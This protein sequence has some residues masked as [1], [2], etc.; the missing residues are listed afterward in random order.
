MGDFSDYMNDII[1]RYG[2]ETGVKIYT[3]DPAVT[4]EN[5]KDSYINIMKENAKTLKSALN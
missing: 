3:L 4:G 2:K 5:S 1:A